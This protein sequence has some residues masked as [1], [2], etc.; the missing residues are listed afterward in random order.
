MIIGITGGIGC[1]KSLAEKRFQE[2]G[3][4]TIDADE[5]SRRLTSQPGT[6]LDQIAA[7]FGPCIFDGPRLN[8]TALRALIFS[9]DQA[10]KQLE[11]I[12]HPLIRSEIQHRLRTIDDKVIVIS[13][14]LLFEKG[15]E[16][17]M[18][19]VIVIDCQPS[20]QIRRVQARNG[21]TSTD[22]RA[23]MA[24]QWPRAKRLR[25][26]D[27]IIDNDLDDLENLNQAVTAV[28]RRI[29]DYVINRSF[30]SNL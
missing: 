27:F 10:R 29:P 15:W 17:F 30:D 6:A 26:A 1:G 2:L 22:V 8:R 11:D 18:D 20:T 12:L 23:I 28:Y 21:W 9:N 19:C 7:R 24:T 16:N 25:H 3:V 5:I 13:V 4:A 14:P